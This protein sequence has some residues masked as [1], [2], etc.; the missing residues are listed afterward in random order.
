[1]Q[2]LYFTPF[3]AIIKYISYKK[4]VLQHE[5]QRKQ[6]QQQSRKLRTAKPEPENQ[7]PH[8]QYGAQVIR[9]DDSRKDLH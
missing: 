1:M 5:L 2:K 6:P 8:E 7:L 3:Y 4:E 9:Q